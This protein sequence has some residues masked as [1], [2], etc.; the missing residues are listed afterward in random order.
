[1]SRGFLGFAR[2]V[3]GVTCSVML[4]KFLG[5]TWDMVHDFINNSLKSVFELFSVFQGSFKIY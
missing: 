2:F 4:L 5:L 3:V 1:M